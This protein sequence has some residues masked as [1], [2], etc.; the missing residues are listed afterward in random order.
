MARFVKDVNLN[1]PAEFVNFMMGDFLQK[2]GYVTLEWKGEECFRCGD[3]MIEGYKYLKWSYMNGIFHLEA[4]MRAPFGGEMGLTGFYGA[5]PKK[6]YRNNLEALILSLQQIVPDMSRM[7]AAAAGASDQPVPVQTVENKGQA[8]AALAVGIGS[9]V[10]ALIMPILGIIVS[11][12]ALSMARSGM[13]S[14][15]RSLAVAGRICAIVG[16]VLAFVTWIINA[17]MLPFLMS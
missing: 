10:G 5:L 3:V 16:L 12:I 7:D 4:W 6:M 2:G 9:I 8:I 1:Q 15:G 17:A 13:N 14:S 11:A